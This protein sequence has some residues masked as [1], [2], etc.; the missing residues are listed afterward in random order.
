MR[1]AK[2]SQEEK[3]ALFLIEVEIQG[4]Q[5]QR[6]LFDLL[7]TGSRI[8]IFCNLEVFFKSLQKHNSDE[9]TQ[10]PI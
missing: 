8:Q 3:I 6:G 4:L 10:C 2:V 5:A 9:T 7:F 1:V